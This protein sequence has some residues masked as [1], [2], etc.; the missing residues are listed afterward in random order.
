MELIPIIVL[1]KWVKS[2]Y[3]GNEH[4]YEYA[5]NGEA[6]LIVFF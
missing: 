4:E 3:D 2:N 6:D 5:L 1:A